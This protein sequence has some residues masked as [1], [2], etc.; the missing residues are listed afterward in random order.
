MTFLEINE[1]PR[2]LRSIQYKND[3]VTLYRKNP[4]L[5]VSSV[6][7]FGIKT[8]KNKQKNPSLTDGFYSTGLRLF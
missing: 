4:S 5:I 8:N 3:E 2:Y 6:A 7:K 1:N